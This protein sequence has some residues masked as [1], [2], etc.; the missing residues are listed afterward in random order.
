VQLDK[1]RIENQIEQMQLQYQGLRTTIDHDDHELDLLKEEAL[2][3]A[4]KDAAQYDVDV[5]KLTFIAKPTA[6]KK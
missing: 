5:D 3:T 1:A 2:K 6:V 4:G